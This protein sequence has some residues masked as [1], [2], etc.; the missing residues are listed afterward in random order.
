MSRV[1]HVDATAGQI[2]ALCE[3][4]GFRLSVVSRCCLAASG[5]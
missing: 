4:N 2:D 3:K 5:S 1:I